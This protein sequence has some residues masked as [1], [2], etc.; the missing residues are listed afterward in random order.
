MFKN[1]KVLVLTGIQEELTGLLSKFQFEFDKSVSCYRSA[2]H[3]DLYA[4]TTGPGLSRKK[5]VRKIIED[6]F[7][8]FIVNGGLTGILKYGDGLPGETLR[9]GCVADARTHTLYPGGRGRDTVV[10]VAQPV[11]EPW[12]K[13]DLAEEFHAR[14]CDME[15]GPLMN[16][17]GQMEGFK[18][19]VNVVFCKVVGDNPEMYELFLGESELRGWQRLSGWGKM[20]A[21]LR[22]SGGPWKAWKLLKLKHSALENLTDSL[23]KVCGILLEGQIPIDM[24]SLFIPH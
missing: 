24:D 3:R 9:V 7:P 10:S 17:I 2:T 13:A 11:F 8:D 20:K 22:F 5:Q 15:A 14:A 12:K 1:L 6:I 16:L 18:N 19:Q 23:E 21:V 4:A